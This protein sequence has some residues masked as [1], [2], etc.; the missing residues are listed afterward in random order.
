VLAHLEAGRLRALGVTSES[1]FARLPDVPTFAEAGYPQL[2]A[3]EWIGLLAPAGTPKPIIDKLNGAVGE[4]L[5]VPGVQEAFH[6]LGVASKAVSPQE[7]GSFMAGETRKWAEVV[8][9]AGIKAE[10]P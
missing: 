7:F 6:K 4:A 5:K 3:F 2:E 1:R 8:A 10:E 9:R